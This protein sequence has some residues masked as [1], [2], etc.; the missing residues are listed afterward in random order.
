MQNF[1]LSCSSSSVVELRR[2]LIWLQHHILNLLNSFQFT[3]CHLTTVSTV[4]IISR[5]WWMNME[6]SWDGTDR[7]QPKY[8]EKNL[9]QYHVVHKNVTWT[10]LEFNR[11]LRGNRPAVKHLRRATAFLQSTLK[12]YLGRPVSNMKGRLQINDIW[13]FRFVGKLAKRY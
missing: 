12:F 2:N 4:K 10:G 7:W 5:R 6:R 1:N 3:V 8:A 13:T 9:A 11:R